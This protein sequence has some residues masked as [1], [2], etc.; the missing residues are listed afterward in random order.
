VARSPNVPFRPKGKLAFGVRSIES[1][2][3]PA[4]VGGTALS[5][6]TLPA[7][8]TKSMKSETFFITPPEGAFR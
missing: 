6:E 8:T 4:G 7:N 3:T 1:S 2:E 5:A